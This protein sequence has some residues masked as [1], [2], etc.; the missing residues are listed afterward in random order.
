MIAVDRD[1][2][3]GAL[4]GAFESLDRLL[5]GLAPGDWAVPTCLPAWDVQANVTHLIGIEAMLLGE[6]EPAVDL[7]PLPHVRNPLGESNERWVRSMAEASPAE[8]LA[9]YRQRVAARLA[10]VEAMPESAWT[11]ETMTPVGPDTYGR[12]MRIR[13]MD[14][15]MHEQDIREALGRP[16]HGD[17]PVVDFVLDEMAPTLGYVVGKKA[18]APDGTTVTFELTGSPGRVVHVAVDGGRAKVVESLPGGA[19][20]TLTMPVFTFTRL[21]GGRRAAADGEVTITGDQ[22]LGQQIVA[23]LAVMI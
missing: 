5:D 4:R 13:T 18:G 11:T 1:Q 12:F 7:G 20:V 14:I 23:A 16:G 10:E 15:W 9:G 21:T 2:A 8:V 19:A 17:G 3:V 6:P 22:A